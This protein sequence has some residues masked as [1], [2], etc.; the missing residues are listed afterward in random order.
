MM[1]ESI[2]LIELW[3]AQLLI[4]FY[5]GIKFQQWIIKKQL[6]RKFK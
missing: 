3:L 6:K 1:W 2:F 5:C 4:A